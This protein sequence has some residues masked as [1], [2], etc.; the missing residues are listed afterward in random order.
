[1][2]L[3]TLGSPLEFLRGREGKGSCQPGSIETIVR[4]CLRSDSVRS[5]SDFFARN[6]A[7]CSGVP[8]EG[9]LHKKFSNRELNFRY[10][11]WD[12]MMGCA[13]NAYVFDTLVLDTLLGR[14]DASAPAVLTTRPF[15]K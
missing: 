6:D 5:W 9:D 10:K 8:L 3:I 15:D 4:D 11:T 7:F 12:S 1:M 13:H 14:T 2:Q